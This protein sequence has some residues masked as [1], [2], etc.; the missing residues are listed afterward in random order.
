MKFHLGSRPYKIYINGQRLNLQQLGYLGTKTVKEYTLTVYWRPGI[1]DVIVNRTSSQNSEASLTRL[2]S[3]DT[4]YTGDTL[5][6]SAIG[7]EGYTINPYQQNV[8]V[9]GDTE[10]YV[11]PAEASW[12]GKPHEIY[13]PNGSVVTVF[14]EE[15]SEQYEQVYI[16]ADFDLQ[17]IWDTLHWRNSQLDAVYLTAETPL[18]LYELSSDFYYELQDTWPEDQFESSAAQATYIKQYGTY[19][20]SLWIAADNE[21]SD[22]ECWYITYKKPK[23]NSHLSQVLQLAEDYNILVTFEP[24]SFDFG[25]YRFTADFAAQLVCKG[26][27]WGGWCID[28]SY[29]TLATPIDIYDLDTYDLEDYNTEGVLGQPESEA[30]YIVAHG[31]YLGSIY[32]DA[33]NQWQFIY[34]EELANE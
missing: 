15:E 34:K 2:Y 19:L 23:L 11:E 12:I 33:Q 7:V 9:T 27:H 8:I 24:E 21:S 1:Q 13:L 32:V 6:I 31:K 28:A 4:I 26:Y 22:K 10:I 16:I 25:A 17:P 20:G 3:G 14:P 18:D 30:A 5:K 29:P